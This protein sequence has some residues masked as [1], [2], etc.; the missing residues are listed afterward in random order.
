[1]SMPYH[2]QYGG[3]NYTHHE[4]HHSGGG[5]HSHIPGL[6]RGQD[7]QASGENRGHLLQMGHFDN[8]NYEN[9]GG[10][11]GQNRGGLELNWKLFHE[12]EKNVMKG[13]MN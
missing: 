5:H 4:G 12:P 9:S 10:G 11:L 13:M 7:H 6:A 3:S 2:D 1:M 8:A